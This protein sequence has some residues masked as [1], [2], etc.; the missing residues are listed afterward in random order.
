MSRKACVRPKNGLG[1]I[2]KSLHSLIS[3]RHKLKE[4][5]S[6]SLGNSILLALMLRDSVQGL[7]QNKVKCLLTSQGQDLD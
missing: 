4:Q 5:S 7:K 2:F 3:P 6:L 1:E